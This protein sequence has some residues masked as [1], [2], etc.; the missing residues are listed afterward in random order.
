MRADIDPNAQVDALLN[1]RNVVIVGA[2]DRPGNWAERVK[3]NLLRYGYPG[4]IYPFNPGRDSVWGAACYKSFADLPEAP[5]HLVVLI[6]AKAVPAALVDAANAGARSA[7]VM[8]SGFD[9]DEAARTLALELKLVIAQTGL[10]V[11]GPNCLGNMNGIAKFMT[12]PD[13]RPQKVSPGPVAVIGQS[14][15]IAMS[16]KRTLEERGTDSGAVITSGNETG[17]TTADYI[18]YFAARSDIRVIVSYLESVHDAD[19]F[20]A[21]CCAARDSG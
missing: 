6:P 21:A 11:S 19:A 4:P 12:M 16:I 2:T 17:L 15:G 8:T 18:R 3:R 14:G 5:D 13:D 9:E 10:A 20:L 1:P 7:T